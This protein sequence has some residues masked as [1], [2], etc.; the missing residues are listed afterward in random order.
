MVLAEK[1]GPAAAREPA[2]TEHRLVLGDALDPS[3]LAPRTGGTTGGRPPASSM[4]A[5]DALYHCWST[6]ILT[7][8]SGGLAGR[9]SGEA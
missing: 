8:V 4:A 5:S 1:P 9:P 6:M 2:Q 3:L 7:I